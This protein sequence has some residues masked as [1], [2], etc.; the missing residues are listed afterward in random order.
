MASLVF[1]WHALRRQ[2]IVAGPVSR[3]SED[4]SD[5]YFASRD[6]TSQMGAWASAQSEVIPDRP[7]LEARVD[8][9]SNRFSDGPV[10]R[11]PHW[12]G[13]RLAPDAVEFWH[14]RPNR[15]HDRLR[16]VRD[17]DGDRWRI[18]RLSP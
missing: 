3:V 11:P 1:P 9:V 6:R 16:Y 17:D 14:S 13:F 15:L 18:I 7:W 5:A 4:E 12:G 10:P 2:V 8:E